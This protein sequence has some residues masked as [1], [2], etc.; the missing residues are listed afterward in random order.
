MKQKWIRGVMTA[1]LLA[2]FGALATYR[3]LPAGAESW[4]DCA[5]GQFCLYDA[6]GGAG[7]SWAGGPTENT[8]TYPA[9]RDDKAVSAWNNTDRWA[10]VYEGA[11]YGGAVQALRPG[12]RGDLA[13]ASVDLTGK[14]SSH[15]AVKSKAGCWTGFERCPDGKLCLFQEP[16]GRGAGT[17]STADNPDYGAAWDNRVLSVWNRTGRHVCFYRAPGWTST[18]TADGRDFKAYVVL[19][20][21]STT[22]PAPYAGTFS[23]HRLVAGTSEC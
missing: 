12:F 5:T 2:G 3:A 20:G 1:V 16:S 9:D 11:S 23:S 13:A 6:A 18:W 15:K 14:V 4:Q 21:R 17:V 7:S 22:V 10:C 19:K 8:Q